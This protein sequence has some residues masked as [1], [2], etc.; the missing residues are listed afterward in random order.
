MTATLLRSA[1]VAP[2]DGPLIPDGALLIEGG[3]IVDVGPAVELRRAAPH[4]AH[5]DFGDSVLL[6]GLVNP[7]THLELSHLTPPLNP[8][9]FIDWIATTVG[10]SGNAATAG[11]SVAAG[12][13][14]SLQFGVTAVG[15]IARHVAAARASLRVSP[16][17]AV[18]FGE[19]VGM[20]RRKFLAADRIAA[21]LAPLP[22]I[23]RPKHRITPA[24]TPH[25]P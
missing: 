18:S 2:M 15:D 23:N 12:A 19:V 13:A 4:A 20:A 6:P 7:H 5:R 10:A 21:A 1:W 14:E 8:G 3:V 11:A 16:L 17:R 9:H 22:D 25:P 24:L